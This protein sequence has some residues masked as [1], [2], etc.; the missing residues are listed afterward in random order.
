MCGFGSTR[1][2]QPTRRETKR[3][4][5]RSD[6][7][8]EVH[9]VNQAAWPFPEWEWQA[10]RQGDPCVLPRASLLWVY[11]LLFVP[12][13][14]SVWRGLTFLNV[15]AWGER[16]VRCVCVVE[17]WLVLEL[18][19]SCSW[20]H[21]HTSLLWSLPPTFCRPCPLADLL[22]TPASLKPEAAFWENS[23]GWT[24]NC[25]CGWA[26]VL[27]S[28]QSCDLVQ[29]I[30]WLWGWVFAQPVVQWVCRR[31]GAWYTHYL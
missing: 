27:N 9:F 15:L 18:S 8:G 24:L 6:A 14:K 11:L 3:W 29:T 1:P 2:T 13:F 12:L 21:E 23:C 28:T 20:W 5:A 26:G 31:L 25:L 10:G 17:V 19:P 7:C 30:R 22:R 4:G 16:L